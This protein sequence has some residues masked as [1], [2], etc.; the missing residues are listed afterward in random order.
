MPPTA[1]GLQ[2]EPEAGTAQAGTDGLLYH[3]I[4]VG[5]VEAGETVGWTFRYTKNDD[6]LTNPPASQPS[7]LATQ[8]A[9]PGATGG[10]DSNWV[11]TFFIAFVALLAVGG[12]AFWLGRSTRAPAGDA[13]AGR[14]RPGPARRPQAL[15]AAF[16]HRCGAELRSDSD[17]CHKCGAPVRN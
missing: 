11:L 10:G 4:E 16:C 3:R 6:E 9:V 15:D 13:P 1:E 14:E 17:F 2:V 8:P 5:A 7:Q 12:A